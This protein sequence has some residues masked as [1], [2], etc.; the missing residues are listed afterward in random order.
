MENNS[1]KEVTERLR[2]I[3]ADLKVPKS[4]TNTFGGYK[5]RNAEDILCAVK[6]IVTLNG[7]SVRISDDV[8]AVS[9]RIYVK[10][11]VT[12]T[13]SYD[14]SEISTSAFARES[15]EKKG[16]DAAQITGAASSYARKYA[17]CG[18]FAIDDGKDPDSWKPNTQ[19]TQPT[20]PTQPT[21][22]TP[23]TQPVKKA[24]NPVDFEDCP[25]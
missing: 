3:Q 22:H 6:P 16:M 14:G 13:C 4:Q 23:N 1:K 15:L 25:F 9:D 5:Y 24:P 20:H 18:M 12:L 7:C 19:H 11:T 8:V 17:L 21:Q 2:I 10:A